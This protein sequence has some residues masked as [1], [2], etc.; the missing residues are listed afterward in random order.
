[1][2]ALENNVAFFQLKAWRLRNNPRVLD[3]LNIILQFRFK[4]GLRR[5]CNLP[6]VASNQTREV[7]GAGVGYDLAT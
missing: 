7:L 2:L 3:P 6:L 5:T 1:V 4:R